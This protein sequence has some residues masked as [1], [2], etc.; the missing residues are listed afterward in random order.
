MVMDIK[1]AWLSLPLVAGF[2]FIC[3][4]SFQQQENAA[5]NAPKQLRFESLPVVGITSSTNLYR[6]KVPGGWLVAS[7]YLK[8][9]NQGGAAGGSGLTFVPDPN[10]SWDGGSPE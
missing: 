4:G 1:K 7:S 6:A 10:H 2:A 5:T 9:N 3:F 8:M